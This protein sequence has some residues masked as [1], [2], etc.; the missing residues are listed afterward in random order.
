MGMTSSKNIYHSGFGPFIPGIHF[1]PF[2]YCHHCP[3]HFEKNKTNQTPT[4]NLQN[5]LEKKREN[6]QML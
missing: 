5:Q 3:V 4:T 2:P 1:T 6:F